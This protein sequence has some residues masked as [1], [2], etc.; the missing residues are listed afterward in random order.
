MLFVD[1]AKIH[2][3]MLSDQ[4]DL[5]IEGSGRDLFREGIES[6]IMIVLRNLEQVPILS[7][8]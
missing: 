4:M 3:L 2:N 1:V 7:T 5:G 6:I 8:S